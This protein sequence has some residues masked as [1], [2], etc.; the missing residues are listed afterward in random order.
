M[1]YKAD[2][3]LAGKLQGFYILSIVDNQHWFWGSDGVKVELVLT[4][5]PSSNPEEIV[6]NLNKLSSS[7]IEF[8]LSEPPAGSL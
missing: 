3:L 7:N 6:E 8:L 2:P 5:A 4:G 1:E